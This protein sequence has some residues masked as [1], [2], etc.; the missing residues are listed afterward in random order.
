MQEVYMCLTFIDRLLLPP[1]ENVPRSWPSALNTQDVS[2]RCTTDADIWPR[3]LGKFE[4][5]FGGLTYAIAR[6]PLS[7]K[8]HLH[9]AQ[10]SNPRC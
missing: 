4:T 6:L 9:L 3:D 10:D 7:V 1:H 8:S 5:V 2:T